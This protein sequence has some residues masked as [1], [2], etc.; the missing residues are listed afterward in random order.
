MLTR[1]FTL[2]LT[3]SLSTLLFSADAQTRTPPGNREVLQWSFAPIVKKA[4]PAVVNV[5]SRRVVQTRSPFFDDPAFRRFFGNQSPFGLPRQRVQQSLG[6][7]VVLD[8]SGLIGTNHHV[9]E[10]AEEITVVLN[11]RREFEAKLLVSDD[12]ADLAVLKI[13]THGEKLAALELGDSD[14]LEVGDLVLAIGNPFGVGQSV[15]SGIVSALARTGIGSDVS[16]FIQTD[17]AIN[18]GNS[19]GALVDLDGRLVGINTAIFSQSGGSVG[20]GFAIPT[21]LVRSTLQAAASGGKIVRPWPGASGQGGRTDVP[22]SLGLPHPEGMLVKDVATGSPAAQA[23]VNGRGVN[24][25]LAR[26]ARHDTPGQP[27]LLATLADVT[28]VLPPPP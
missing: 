3:L 21:S 26:H 13:D 24:L 22:P 6:S 17:A 4:A 25:P 7:G 2:G 16:S 18:P 8:A 28:P 15:S 20:I 14:Q 19:G 1:I 23:A 10:A 9:I 12:R 27:F 5:Y 11:D